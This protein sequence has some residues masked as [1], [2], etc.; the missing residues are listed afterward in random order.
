MDRTRSP[1]HFFFFFS[2]NLF[3]SDVHQNVEQKIGHYYGFIAN[4][5]TSSTK[6]Q[7]NQWQSCFL[8]VLSVE[9]VLRKLVWKES[10]FFTVPFS[11]VDGA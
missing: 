6:Q 2:N 10:V 1:L 4:V 9:E 8:L 5:K 11:D 7:F 3:Y